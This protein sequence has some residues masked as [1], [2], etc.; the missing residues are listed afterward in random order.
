[1][2]YP[3]L[4]VKQK[5]RQMSDA[6]LGYNH[7]LRIGDSEFYDMKNMTSDYYPVL[8]PRKNRGV[9]KDGISANSLIA[10]D[11]LCYVDGS[12]F[13]IGDERIE[14]GLNDEPKN[15]VSMGAYVIIMP[16]KKWINTV[17]TDD[18]GDI[19]YEHT[20]TG[21]VKFNLCNMVGDEYDNLRPGEKPIENDGTVW[22]DT[23]TTPP[24]LKQY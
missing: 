24:T 23:S 19:E 8:A 2:E 13:V 3:T 1:M 7:N 18:H 6:F 20:T 4:N 12:A 10:K 15:L 11:K 14:M 16:D 21:K 17:N 22:L 9:Y 5:S